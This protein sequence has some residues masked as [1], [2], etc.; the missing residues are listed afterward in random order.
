MQLKPGALCGDLKTGKAWLLPEQE[1]VQCECKPGRMKA[2]E[3]DKTQARLVSGKNIHDAYRMPNGFPDF[4]QGW[5]H[6]SESSPLHIRRTFLPLTLQ[7]F[8]KTYCGL[9]EAQGK[10]RYVH[11]RNVCWDPGKGLHQLTNQWTMQEQSLERCIHTCT[12]PLTS[13]GGLVV[14]QTYGAWESHLISL[15]FICSLMSAP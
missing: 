5:F 12:H 1:A 6:Q 11:P 10:G 8:T 13:W 4:L 15:A 7:P 3:L 9:Q 2:G 14:S